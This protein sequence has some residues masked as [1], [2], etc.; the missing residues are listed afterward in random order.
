MSEGNADC[1]GSFYRRQSGLQREPWMFGWHG[2]KKVEA[3]LQQLLLVKEEKHRTLF[4]D[5]VCKCFV[6]KRLL[7]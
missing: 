4:W 1:P 3:D 2:G 5:Y 6:L 7:E